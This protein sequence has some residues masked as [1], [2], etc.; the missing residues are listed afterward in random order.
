MA[1]GVI[2]GRTLPI[3]NIWE[4]SWGCPLFNATMPHW[5]FLK[6]IKFLKFDLKTERRRN[7]VDEKFCLA[8][9]L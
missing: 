8:Y 9:L 5:R 3:K 7:L 4:K 2:V 6:I 1:L